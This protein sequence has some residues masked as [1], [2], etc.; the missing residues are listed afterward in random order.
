[1]S[2]VAT[3]PTR[4]VLSWPSALNLTDEAGAEPRSWIQVAKTGSFVS[5]QYGKFAITRDD[6]AQMLHNFANVTPKA[7]TELP[8]DYDHLSMDPKKPGDG[9]AAGWVKKL[10]LRDGGDALWAEVEWTPK[11]AEAIKNREYQFVS[12]SF[13]KGHTYKDGSQIGTTLLAA[14]ITNHPFLEGMQALTLRTP[15]IAGVHL[16]V[17]LRD[18]VATED[19]RVS[20]STVIGQRVTVGSQ[21]ART[22]Q[23]V[24]ATFEVLKVEGMPGDGDARVWLKD[25]TTGVP[26]GWYRADE[27]EPARAANA[28]PLPPDRPQQE[29]TTM[30]ANNNADDE[31][32]ALSNKIARE[33]GISLRD[34]TIEA[35]RRLPA[36]VEQRRA[37]IGAETTT[38]DADMQARPVINLR[39]G[40]SFFAL[41]Q[42]TAAERQ[43]HLSQAIRLVGHAHPNLAE[44][45]GRGEF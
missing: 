15:A 45:Y 30:H 23:H 28:K 43:I 33:Q 14:A 39:D 41:C 29:D 12:P 1:M 34:A 25:L 13:V 37:A 27:L 36:L 42:R 2:P 6:L 20:L 3:L 17:A 11:A 21:H 22:P 24:G 5:K 32:I 10:E 19:G 40:E 26:I 4:V 8:I 38:D 31:L 7:P 18:L 35:G 16:S 9:V 44:A